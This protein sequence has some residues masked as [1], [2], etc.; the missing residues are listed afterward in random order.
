MSSPRNAL[1]R[2]VLLAYAVVAS[3]AQRQYTIVNKCPSSI[4][5]YIAGAKDSTLAQGA[6]ATKSLSV[7]AGFFYTNANGGSTDGQAT[8]AGFYGDSSVNYYYIVKNSDHFNTGMSI[9]PNHP[10]ANGLC[11]T[12]TCDS[13]S[14]TAFDQPPTHIIP[15]TNGDP[16]SPPM[17]SCPFADVAYT[18]T[19]C[20]SGSFPGD[21]MLGVPVHPNFNPSKCLD[22]RGAVFA[23][24]TPVQIYDCN[25]TG[26]QSWVLNKESTKVRVAG[27]NFCLDAGSTPANAVG[28]KIWTCYDN[29]PAQQ[30]FYTDDNR[31]ALQNGLCL[32]LPNGVLANSNQLQTWQCT[33]NNNNQ[34]WSK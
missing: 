32:D 3:Q 13:A 22:V 25:G 9:A 10:A 29:L 18:I 26:A 8:R 31:I 12:I 11:P 23:D 28:M 19:F 6:T 27:T 21:A 30:W 20:P 1:L 34:V 17:Y 16:P 7:D 5:L 24:G 33:D 15:P 4:D 2:V 14:C